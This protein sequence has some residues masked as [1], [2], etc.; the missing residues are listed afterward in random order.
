MYFERVRVTLVRNGRVNRQSAQVIQLRPCTSGPGA[1]RDG[2]ALFDDTGDDITVERQL[3]RN[4]AQPLRR[5]F[6]RR[7]KSCP[8]L[9]VLIPLRSE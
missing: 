2:A 3:N 6:L 7:A 4:L 5:G 8:V 9:L 1:Y